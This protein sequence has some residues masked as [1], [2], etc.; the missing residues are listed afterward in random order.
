VTEPHEE[1]AA[2]DPR[3]ARLI[4]AVDAERILQR[5]SQRSEDRF[6]AL[7]RMAGIT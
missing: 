5:R 3:L 7:A 4:A 1:L 6:E 2:A